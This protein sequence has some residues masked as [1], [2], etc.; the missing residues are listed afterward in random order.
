MLDDL[1]EHQAWCASYEPAFQPSRVISYISRT[2]YVH[3]ATAQLHT[4]HT[5]IRLAGACNCF[6]VAWAVSSGPRGDPA[7]P[8]YG[9][10]G[11]DSYCGSRDRGEQIPGLAAGWAAYPRPAG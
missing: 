11:L 6:S 5:G 9:Q 1:G 3:T 10:F 4:F 2:R 8:E 7:L